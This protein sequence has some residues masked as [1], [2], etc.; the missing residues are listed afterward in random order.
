MVKHMLIITTTLTP[1]PCKITGE[2]IDLKTN[3]DKIQIT[4]KIN[5]DTITDITL[6]DNIL[7]N[8]KI[9][10]DTITNISTPIT[11]C[12]VKVE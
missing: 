2:I 4:L 7:I 12:E 6:K 1:P 3:K 5:Q 10:T 11:T 9:D 8:Y